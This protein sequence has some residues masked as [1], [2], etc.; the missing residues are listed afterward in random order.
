[1]IT[2]TCP[3]CDGASNTGGICAQ[4]AERESSMADAKA[5]YFKAVP[6]SSDCPHTD[7]EHGICIECGKDIWDDIVARAESAAEAKEDR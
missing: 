7:H 1:M 6:K 3:L 5:H 2:T 4:C